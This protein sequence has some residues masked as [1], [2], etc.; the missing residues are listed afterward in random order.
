[1]I[2]CACVRR[3]HKF[4][5]A[6]SLYWTRVHDEKAHGVHYNQQCAESWKTALFIHKKTKEKTSNDKK[7]RKYI[8]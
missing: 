5:F 2:V 7:R 6:T 8:I 1:M 4:V 3:V